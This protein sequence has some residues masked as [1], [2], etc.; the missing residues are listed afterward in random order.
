MEPQSP[1]ATDS[2]RTRDCLV[3]TTN[4]WCHSRGVSGL[5]Y[6]PNCLTLDLVC[7]RTIRPGQEAEG[8]LAQR[9]Q[10]I[11]HWV[12]SQVSETYHRS[13][14][15]RLVPGALQPAGRFA[16]PPR[17]S[18]SHELVF[19]GVDRLR[20]VVH[21]PRVRHS[22]DSKANSKRVIGSCIRLSVGCVRLC[23]AVETVRLSR[24]VVCSP[25][26]STYPR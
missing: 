18:R 3:A 2:Q 23:S 19:E 26:C 6:S 13:G 5:G 22:R 10:E 9:F 11:A 25:F 24:T 14:L 17:L 16:L 4:S 1:L 7:N 15:L 21:L 20:N 8:N 12:L